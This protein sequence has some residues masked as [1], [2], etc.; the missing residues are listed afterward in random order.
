ML[1]ITVFILLSYLVG[2]VRDV[3]PPEIADLAVNAI[4]VFSTRDLVIVLPS[5]ES[6][7]NFKP[8]DMHF[9]KLVNYHVLIVT[10]VDGEHGFKGLST[11]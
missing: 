8:D 5:I 4:E 10:A 7:R 1:K 2:K 11:L 6:V 3:F 9:R